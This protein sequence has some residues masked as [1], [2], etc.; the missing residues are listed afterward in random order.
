MPD[1]LDGESLDGVTMQYVSAAERM[2][3][4]LQYQSAIT[5]YEHFTAKYFS[6]THQEYERIPAVVFTG[7]PIYQD[8]YQQYIK[9]KGD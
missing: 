1:L 8:I 9:Q 2:E 5:F 6:I 4:L 7:L 3:A